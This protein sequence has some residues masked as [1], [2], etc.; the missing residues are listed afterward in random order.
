MVLKMSGKIET[1][2]AFAQVGFYRLE[3]AT[4]DLKEEQLDWK[5]CPQAN[6]IRWLLTHL[7]SELHSFVPK[8]LKGDKGYKPEGW[9]DDYVGNKAYTL[10]KI[11]ADLDE[12]KKKLMKSLDKL[13]EEELAVEMDWFYG[14]RPKEAYLMLAISEIHHHEGQIAAILGLES[15]MKGVT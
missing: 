5:S 3:R 6:T 13:T 9:P 7:S 1:I 10:K 15:R 14:K 12:G 2:K 4:K 8:I 11:N